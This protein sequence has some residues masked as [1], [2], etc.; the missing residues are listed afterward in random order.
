M[1][2]EPKSRRSKTSKLLWALALLSLSMVANAQMEVGDNVKMNLN[3]N[4]GFG[5]NGSFGNADLP[6][7]T[8]Y[9]LAGNANLTGYYFHPNFLNFQIHPYYDR[10]EFHSDSQTSTQ[11]SGLSASL[12]LFGGSRFPGSVS[13]GKDYSSTSQFQFAGVPGVVG[14]GS[15]QQ[16][17]LNWSALLPNW[18]Q[19]YASYY[20]G[21][22]TSSVL[23]ATEDSR[24]TSKNLNLSST[25]RIVGF[26]LN[27]TVAH[28][29]TGF[30]SPNFFTP[31][32][33]TTSGASTTYSLSAQ[34][35][36]PLNGNLGLGWSRGTYG[37]D[38][39]S[40]STSNS[41]SAGV[42]FS[43]W[44]RLT[45][46]ENV[47]Y[48]SNLATAYTQSVLGNSAARPTT[49]DSDSHG[50]GLN[51][52]ASYHIGKGLSASGHMSRRE[53][54]FSGRHYSDTQYGGTLTY[55]KF[56][57][58][59]GFLNLGIGVVDTAS[60]VGN[61]GTGLMANVG[62]S[63]KFGHWDTTGEFS[64]TQNLQTLVA[65]QATS[66]YTY[67]GTIRRKINR[68]THW[69]GSYRAT[70]TGMVVQAGSGSSTQSISSSISW[71]RYS[72][73]GNY[74]NS[75]GTAILTQSGELTPVPG[76]GFFTDGILLY[77]ARS[78]GFSA[79]AKVGRNIFG[80]GGYGNSYSDSSQQNL[81]NTAKGDRYVSRLEYRLRKFS[82]I[83][84]FNRYGQNIS[85]VAGGP[86][87]VNS[88][89]LSLTRWFNVF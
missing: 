86:R 41:Y 2:S 49:Y 88:Y 17:A 85:T 57:R 70:R 16:L 60:K 83:G 48:T 40:D 24:S 43:P 4:L 77:N 15:G 33:L 28:A 80:S 21:S 8:G 42:G 19:F 76:G 53:Q 7:S 29:N 9:G 30:T 34:H 87:I 72:F 82:V 50:L 31:V 71:T 56:S 61:N 27:G 54:D 39:A 66:S 79:S 69:N 65:L 22:S 58:L 6:T 64:Y 25:Y 18:P 1:Y 45:I 44:Q 10:S 35:K 63:H 38:G 89:Y 14:D 62:M 74:S 51:T 75:S 11:G 47:I 12:G 26:D 37:L 5:Y 52:F 32:A 3:G 46:S 36:L 81:Y 73:S 20:I 55:N 13:F 78:F 23:G 68:D 59:F 84:G 67:G